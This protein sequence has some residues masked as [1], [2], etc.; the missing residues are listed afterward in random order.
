MKTNVSIKF[1]SIEEYRE[2][3]RVLEGL[4]YNNNKDSNESELIKHKKGWVSID[5]IP[6]NGRDVVSFDVFDFALDDKVYNSL[7]E[8][9]K[10]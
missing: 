3:E 6:T 2:I 7:Q 4:G 10:D 1:N 9:L 5:D 8:F